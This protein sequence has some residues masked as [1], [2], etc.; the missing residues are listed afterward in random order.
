M[1]IGIQIGTYPPSVVPT[2]VY[3]M[4][5]IIL[6]ALIEM[7]LF[8]GC[9]KF[10]FAVTLSFRT[11]FM[12]HDVGYGIYYSYW[13]SNYYVEWYCEEGTNSTSIEHHC[14]ENGCWWDC[15]YESSYYCDVCVRDCVNIVNYYIPFCF[16]KILWVTT[17]AIFFISL[18]LGIATVVVFS[19]LPSDPCGPCCRSCCC[20]SKSSQQVYSMQAAQVQPS[21]V[22]VSNKDFSTLRPIK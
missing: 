22:T 20:P 19:R 9:R 7:A 14:R 17:S 18:L 1:K 3:T 15:N 2:I 4:S 11:I 8:F 12:L 21:S 5:I 10:L 6:Y 13:A 16:D